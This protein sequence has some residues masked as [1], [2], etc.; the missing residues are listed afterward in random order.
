M[1]LPFNSTLMNE[2]VV[3]EPFAIQTATQLS[4]IFFLSDTPRLPTHCDFSFLQVRKQ[5]I[6][7]TN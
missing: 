4:M 6:L 3:K 1:A 5:G 2:L 7:A